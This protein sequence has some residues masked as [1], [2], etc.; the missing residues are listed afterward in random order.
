[1]FLKTP[2]YVFIG[3]LFNGC[4][5]TKFPAAVSFLWGLGAEEEQTDKVVEEPAPEEKH[6][7]KESMKFLFSEK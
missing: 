6:A 4:H 1:M 3:W 7:R 5:Y 2:Q